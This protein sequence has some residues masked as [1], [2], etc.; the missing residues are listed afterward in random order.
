MVVHDPGLGRPTFGIGMDGTASAAQDEKLTLACP[1]PACYQS[2]ENYRR[3]RGLGMHQ[4]EID[5]LANNPNQICRSL[6]ERLNAYYRVFPQLAGFTRLATDPEAMRQADFLLQLLQHAEPGP[7]FPTIERGEAC[8]RTFQTH[9]PDF[10]M[11]WDTLISHGW[12]RCFYS[13]WNLPASQVT[14]ALNTPGTNQIQA[15]LYTLTEEFI[16]HKRRLERYPRVSKALYQEKMA[17]LGIGEDHIISKA[18]T[19]TDDSCIISV[20]EIK[21][22]VLVSWLFAQLWQ[23]NRSRHEFS[24]NDERYS[25]WILLLLASEVYPSHMP[26]FLDRPEDILAV[27]VKWILQ[28]KDIGCPEDEKKKASAA[29]ALEYGKNDIIAYYENSNGRIKNNIIDSFADYC[30][31]SFVW[32]SETVVLMSYFDDIHQKMDNGIMLHHLVI[33]WLLEWEGR[34]L[35]SHYSRRDIPLMH[36]ILK[37]GERRPRFIEYFIERTLQIGVDGCP[38]ILPYLL[39]VRENLN[40]VGLALATLARQQSH[41]FAILKPR[42]M[43]VLEAAET[44]VIH[45]E[46]WRDSVKLALAALLER[47][48]SCFVVTPAD[49]VAHHRVAAGQLVAVYTQ[50]AGEVRPQK[51]PW[52]TTHRPRWLEERLDIFLQILED[53]PSPFDR[54]VSVLVPLLPALVCSVKQRLAG[55]AGQ[56][57]ILHRPEISLLLW[58]LRRFCL[59][60]STEGWTDAVMFLADEYTQVTDPGYRA[61]FPIDIGWICAGRWL[62]NNEPERFGRMLQLGEFASGI[63]NLV[64][65]SGKATYGRMANGIRGHL[66]LHLRFLAFLVE[67]WE[68]DQSI[69]CDP[70]HYERLTGS[71]FEQLCT[72]SK[73]DISNGTLDILK[74]VSGL[75]ADESRGMKPLVSSIG[76]AI[77]AIRGN[78]RLDFIRS[79][80]DCTEEPRRL[81]QLYS[82]LTDPESRRLVR[83][84]LAA[85]SAHVDAVPLSHPTIVEIFSII[86]GLLDAD[87]PEHAEGYLVR[88]EARMR[89]IWKGQWDVEAFRLKLRC[90]LTRG[91]LQKLLALSPSPGVSDIAEAQD[92]LNFYRAIALMRQTPKDYAAAAKIFALLRERDPAEEVY[93]VNWLAART[94]EVTSFPDDKEP[95]VAERTRMLTVITETEKFVTSGHSIAKTEQFCQN[96]LFLL[97]R[98]GENDRL[99]RFFHNLPTDWQRK[100]N[101]YGHIN[102]ASS[103]AENKH[104][105][106]SSLSN[107]QRTAEIRRQI[108]RDCKSDSDLD[109]FLLDYF[110]SVYQ[111]IASAMTRD[112]KINLLFQK[113]A[114]DTIADFL[115][116]HCADRQTNEVVLVSSR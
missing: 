60:P 32:D 52:A 64:T 29:L 68:E 54:S 63:R 16:S 24:S 73:E 43:T 77:S 25:W 26:F 3:L 36:V 8:L 104:G 17:L 39:T 61:D 74:I 40:I 2:S 41:H 59:G 101:F 112:Q 91:N 42:A 70:A 71:F 96:Y 106:E 10:Q 88:Y 115:K 67:K 85:R 1:T 38:S 82:S 51:N 86:D 99:L 107:K 31:K 110:P 47:G 75:D 21:N 78:K 30:D 49:L 97:R 80:V 6:E 56:P 69:S 5:E 37:E 76:R 116:E 90:E 100:P 81:G 9:H 50:L 94:G 11:S 14:N 95:S 66:R 65:D 62:A 23:K 111:Q 12:I 4:R 13:S 20:G 114:I 34:S 55:V 89:D 58:L 22:T 102:P 27:S 92:T 35:T 57:G 72:N 19:V 28:E 108:Y 113:I 87:L 84:K 48:E 109:A 103:E 33:S 53:W 7:R 45:R 79:Y 98:V 93:A 105:A 18:V 15:F 44:L 46:V 83:E